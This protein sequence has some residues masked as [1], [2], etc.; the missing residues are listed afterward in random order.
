MQNINKL[1]IEI[2]NYTKDI[3]KDA[4]R[5]HLLLF[6]LTFFSTTLNQFLLGTSSDIF[7]DFLIAISYSVPLMIILLAHEMG[8]FLYAKRYNVDATLPYFIPLPFISP[9][10]TLGAFIKM[11][12]LPPDKNALLDI[13]FWGPA[14]SFSLAIPFSIAG[15]MMSEV[16][17]ITPD[18]GGLYFGEPLI[19]KMILHSIKDV[20]A[21]HDVLLHPMAFAGWVGFLVTAINLFPI[22]QLD[23]GHIAYAVLGKRQ[24][25]LA[26]LFMGIIILLSFDFFGWIFFAAMIY[27]MIGIQHPPYLENSNFKLNRKQKRM[28]VLSILMLIFSFIAVPVT[29]KEDPSQIVPPPSSPKTPDGEFS[30]QFIENRNKTYKKI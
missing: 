23:G 19:F 20:P 18:L 26:Y 25:S 28:A 24:K 29:I 17:P 6:V 9:I 16:I 7:S 14:M 12:S 8:H 2:F 11:K 30:V 3:P 4:K 15:I 5:K 27:F 10:G 13:A 22:G 1:F 21:G